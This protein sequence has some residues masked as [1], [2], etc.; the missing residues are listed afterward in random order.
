MKTIVEKKLT[1]K[2]IFA[3][4]QEAHQAKLR[5]ANQLLAKANLSGLAAI[6]K[7]KP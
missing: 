3:N 6:Q 5:E 1:P 4:E 7:P 2:S